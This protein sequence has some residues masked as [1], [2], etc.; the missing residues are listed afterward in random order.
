M[1]T[2]RL[3]HQFVLEGPVDLPDGGG[4]MSRSWSTL[5]TLWGALD[6]RSAGERVAGGREIA[7]LTHRITI[8]SAPMGSPQRPTEAQRLRRGDRIFAIRGVAEADEGPGYLELFVEEG[9]FS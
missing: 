9:P 2:P 1:E 8:R 7:T 6:S 5:G 3:T 4:G